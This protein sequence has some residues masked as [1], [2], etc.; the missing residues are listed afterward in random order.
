MLDEQ[1]NDFHNLTYTFAPEEQKTPVFHEPLTEYLCFPTVFLRPTHLNNRNKIIPVYEND[2]FKYEL[3]S[4]DHRVAM[5]IPNIFWTE[6]HL[7]NK[8]ITDNV[9]LAVWWN[10]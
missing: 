7:Q 2:I 3:Y 4:V 5:N 9:S 10:K 1:H 8:Q 6:K